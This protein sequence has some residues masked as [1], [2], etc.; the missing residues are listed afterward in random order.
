M[1]TGRGNQEGDTNIENEIFRDFQCSPNGASGFWKKDMDSLFLI[2]SLGPC[3]L[4][5]F[6]DGEN[7]FTG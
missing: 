2:P 1:N 3:G 6:K 5:I 7:Q 4:N